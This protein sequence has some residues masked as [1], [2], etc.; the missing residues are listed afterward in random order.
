M[1]KEKKS[2]EDLSAMA[3]ETVQ[4]ARRAMENYLDFFQKNMSGAPWASTELNQKVTD[5]ARQNV[6]SAFGFAQRLT[7]AK[8]L[9]DLVRIQSEFFQAQLESLTKQA[10]D[11]GEMATKAVT[12]TLKNPY[13]PS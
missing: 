13:P 11:L 10:K 7:S 5:Y 9:Q 3:G 1:E 2:S 6:D 12:G 4:Q 8:D